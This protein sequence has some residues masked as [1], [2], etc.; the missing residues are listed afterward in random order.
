MWVDL[1][2]V[3]VDCLAGR[4]NEAGI[5]RLTKAASVDIELWWRVIAG[6]R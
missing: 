6:L 4:E 5:E 1:W 2:Q 3:E